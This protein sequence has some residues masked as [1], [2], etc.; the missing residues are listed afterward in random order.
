[1]LSLSGMPNPPTSW[2]D[3]AQ[4][5]PFTVPPVS[6]PP[7]SLNTV[8]SS[9]AGMAKEFE[10]RVNSEESAAQEMMTDIELEPDVEQAGVTKM[11]ETIEIPPDLKKMGV[12]TMGST[13]VFAS[14]ASLKLPLTDDQIVTGLHSQVLMSLRWLSEWCIKRL[15]IAHVHLKVI[16]GGKVVRERE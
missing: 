7:D 5:K 12:Q 4:Q 10:P 11:S 16:T 6:Q 8:A 13:A 14:N 15:K 1:M 3:D 9:G 2:S